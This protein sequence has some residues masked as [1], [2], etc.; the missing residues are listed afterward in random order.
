VDVLQSG[1][2]QP[3]ANWVQEIER[4]LDSADFIAF[5]ISKGSVGDESWAQQAVQIVLSRQLSGE[6]GPRLL[7]IL[8]E[9]AEVPPLLKQIQWLDMRDGDVEKGVGRLVE[10]IRHYSR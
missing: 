9:D 3:G 1:G 8:L 2:I 5:F 10:V 7:P 6:G 4:V